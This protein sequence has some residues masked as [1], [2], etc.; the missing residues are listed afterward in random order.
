MAYFSN[1]LDVIFNS[2]FT[3]EACLKII[4]YGFVFGHDTYLHDTWNIM[5]FFIV[6]SA[7]ID[8]SVD[9]I[10]IPALKILRM[11]RTLRPLRFVSHNINMKIV[12]T[13]LMQSLGAIMNV[14]IVIILIW[15]MFAILG[16]S[17]LQFKLGYCKDV[18]NYYNISK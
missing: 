4:S 18:V 16:M 2:L 3:V 6:V 10:D 5:D 15:L 8:M 7:L 14:L 13:A 9:S 1:L 12:V 11:L 17:L